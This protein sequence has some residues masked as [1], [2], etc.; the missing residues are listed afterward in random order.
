MLH[1]ERVRCVNK[2]VSWKSRKNGLASSLCMRLPSL[3]T[4]DQIGGSMPT[5]QSYS[6]KIMSAVG[7]ESHTHVHPGVNFWRG[8]RS[9]HVNLYG[10]GVG[11][12]L[13]HFLLESFPAFQR[14]CAVA[15]SSVF[16]SS[17]LKKVQAISS[18]KHLRLHL[19]NVFLLSR[20]NVFKGV[21]I[22]LVGMVLKNIDFKN[23]QPDK[24]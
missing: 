8:L 3:Y 12:C 10:D 13:F 1:I 2:N 18:M 4:A 9:T 11:G 15:M 5:W 7:V 19:L 20:S 23:Y 14:F 22:S 16:G 17:N 21:F 24:E 6:N